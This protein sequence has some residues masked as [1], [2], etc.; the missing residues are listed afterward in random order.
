[1]IGSLGEFEV[2]V[3]TGVIAAG[4]DA[5]GM[6][7]HEQVEA[8]VSA[9]RNVAIGAIYTTL[10]RLEEKGYVKSWY[11]EATAER[12]GRAKRYFHVTGSGQRALNQALESMKRAIQVLDGAEV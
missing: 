4:D 7:I 11:G 3:L 2:L 8:L 9:K 12:G 6:V 1:M 5:Y 10:G